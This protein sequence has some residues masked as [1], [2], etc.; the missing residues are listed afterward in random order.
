[1]KKTDSRLC[2][3]KFLLLWNPKYLYRAHKSLPLVRVLNHLIQFTFSDFVYLKP[4][5][6]FSD[7][8]AV[9]VSH[10]PNVRYMSCPLRPSLL[11]H[12]NNIGCRIQIMNSLLC[13]FPG[14]PAPSFLVS[15]IF[16]AILFSNTY[17]V[18]CLSVID[19]IFMKL[20]VFLALILCIVLNCFWTYAMV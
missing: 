9:R 16:L 2:V 14:F 13:A 7:G 5:T 12:P 3:H 18:S 17:R 6:S 8:N 11:N 19:R 4:V 10:L 15:N 20:G 1:M